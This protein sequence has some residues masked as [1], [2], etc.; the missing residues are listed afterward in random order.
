MKETIAVVGMLIVWMASIVIIGAF[1]M[2]II[3][4]LKIGANLII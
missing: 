3:R 1:G 4:L 2:F